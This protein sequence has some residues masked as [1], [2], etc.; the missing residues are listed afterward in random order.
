MLS[1]FVQESRTISEIMD[2]LCENPTLEKV[3]DEFDK[4]K[5]DIDLKNFLD[6]NLCSKY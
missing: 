2:E 5:I 1:K 6:A 3:S 4:M